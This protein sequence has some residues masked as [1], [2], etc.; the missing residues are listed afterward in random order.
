MTRS[1]QAEVEDETS[2]PRLHP[3]EPGQLCQVDI[4]PHFLTGGESVACFNAIDVV[5]R[6]PTGQA[7]GR[8]RSLDAMAFLIHVWQEIGIPH[9]TQVDNEA[10]FSGG[11]THPGV[12]GKV[13]RLALYVGTELVFSPVR[14]PQS[15]GY[16]ERFHQDYDL[17]VWQDTH[18]LDRYDVQAHA[19]VFFAN[20]R[21]SRHHSALKG[22]SPMDVHT[23][24]ALPK[25]SADFVLPQAKLPL[26]QG[27]VHF[28]RRVDSDKTIS[29]LNLSWVVSQ[30][31][32]QQGVWVT[33]HF[34]PSQATLQVYDQAPDVLERRC[35]A[36][37]P[38]PLKEP[39]QSFQLGLQP[40]PVT[41]L[42]TDLFASAFN[43][44]RVFF[45][46]MF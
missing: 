19:D 3:T 12:L 11:F 45:S 16:V 28:M 33:I 21:H 29:V 17:H 22:H 38:F 25:L 9:Y 44:V 23:R 35:L 6:Y 32:P 26:T 41:S 5:S 13:L 18:L 31:E 42:W 4:V 34:Q 40:R 30:A 1:G 20:Y 37:H 8:R 15:N 7:C 2:Y 10:C 27:R 46:T 14:H 43:H 39:V 24:S 36:E